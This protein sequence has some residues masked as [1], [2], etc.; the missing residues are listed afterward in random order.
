MTELPFPFDAARPMRE[1]NLQRARKIYDFALEQSR[2]VEQQ[3]QQDTSRTT[4]ADWPT[5]RDLGIVAVQPL[6]PN[7]TLLAPRELQKQARTLQNGSLS[8]FFAGT[9]SVIPSGVMWQRFFLKGDQRATQI[10]FENGLVCDIGNVQAKSAQDLPRLSLPHVIGRIAQCIQVAHRLYA[11][12]VEGD[13]TLSISFN[14]LGEHSVELVMDRGWAHDYNVA[15]VE[16]WTWQY[17]IPQAAFKNVTE[18][19]AFIL[20]VV[21]EVCWGLGDS[22]LTP[23]ALSTLGQQLGLTLNS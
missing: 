5:K 14:D 21:D 13:W 6:R 18:L 20:V 12:N 11:T 3:R 16:N 7:Q 1:D 4:S 9:N 15:L 23:Q 19:N 22:Q 8:N 2:L 10:F 17:L